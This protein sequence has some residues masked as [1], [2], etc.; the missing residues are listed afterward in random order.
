MSKKKANKEKH[1]LP[2]IL[3]QI[4]IQKLDLEEKE[5]KW[6]EEKKGAI[7]IANNLNRFRI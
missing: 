5:Q 7:I 1:L 2:L 3:D 6:L 4:A